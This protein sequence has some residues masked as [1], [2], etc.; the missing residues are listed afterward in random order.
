MT[1]AAPISSRVTSTG[2]TLVILDRSM[3]SIARGNLRRHT[4]SICRASWPTPFCFS[5]VCTSFFSISSASVTGSSPYLASAVKVD[6]F[7]LY[8]ERG[9]STHHYCVANLLS[10]VRKSRIW[11]KFIVRA[12]HGFADQPIDIPLES[13]T[14]VSMELK[15]VIAGKGIANAPKC[16]GFRILCEERSIGHE[17]KVPIVKDGLVLE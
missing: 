7:C 8:K 4:C 11:M 2:N 10:I 1:K 14:P 12:I 5:A 3:P 17:V 6:A 13:D 9:I 15:P 16:P